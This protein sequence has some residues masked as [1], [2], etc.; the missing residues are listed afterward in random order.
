LREDCGQTL[1]GENQPHFEERCFFKRQAKVRQ[2]FFFKEDLRSSRPG[3]LSKN[4]ARQIA[5]DQHENT[6]C[7]L[8]DSPRFSPL[9]SI[10]SA[11]TA[12]GKRVFPRKRKMSV[13][14]LGE[15]YGKRKS[16]DFPH[17]SEG[18]PPSFPAWRRK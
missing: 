12:F 4:A 18:Q 14:I 5:G 15:L 13:V 17:S 7:Q 10:L 6:C 11:A 3:T 2:V 1:E 8:G 16:G 9:N